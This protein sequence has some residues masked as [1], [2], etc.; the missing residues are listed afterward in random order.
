MAAQAGIHLAFVFA[1]VLLRCLARREKAQPSPRKADR[2]GKQVNNNGRRHRRRR[3]TSD[4][5]AHVIHAD[6]IWLLYFGGQN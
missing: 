1:A 2:R 4:A 6:H 3:G 5:L